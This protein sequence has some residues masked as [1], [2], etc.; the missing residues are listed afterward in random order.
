MRPID[1]VAYELSNLVELTILCRSSVLTLFEQ[2]PYLVC[3]MYNPSYIDNIDCVLISSV[4][5][6]S[7][8]LYRREDLSVTSTVNRHIS[9]T[10]ICQTSTSSVITIRTMSIIVHLSS[11]LQRLL[12]VVRTS[13]YNNTACI[14]PIALMIL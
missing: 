12:V 3:S 1:D 5:H 7:I 8:F 6:S 14:L 11:T 4:S 10:M 13:I 9:S 2:Y